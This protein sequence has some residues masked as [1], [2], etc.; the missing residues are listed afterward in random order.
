MR[1]YL[2]LTLI[3]TIHHRLC[4]N[5][6]QGTNT[7]YLLLVIDMPNINKLRAPTYRAAILNILL[8]V[9]RIT[10]ATAVLVSI[11]YRGS[12]LSKMPH[13]SLISTSYNRLVISVTEQ[14]C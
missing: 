13:V 1:S 12:I 10:R 8:H 11:R 5:Q 4:Y 2:R 14:R 6:L 3:H 9:R 7:E